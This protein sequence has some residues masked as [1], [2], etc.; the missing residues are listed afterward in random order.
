MPFGSILEAFGRSWGLHVPPSGCQRGSK[1]DAKR[2]LGAK[3]A[4][5][6][7]WDL[8][9]ED[10]GRSGTCLGTLFGR[11]WGTLGAPSGS[12]RGSTRVPNETLASKSL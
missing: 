10:L 2:G 1:E 11:S 4:P 7:L 5:S 9:F 8:I 6:R 12:Q 3:V